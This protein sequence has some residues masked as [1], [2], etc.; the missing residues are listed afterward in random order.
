MSRL[1]AADVTIKKLLEGS[2]VIQCRA[3]TAKMINGESTEI[4]AGVVNIDALYCTRANVEA[5]DDITVGLSRGT[6]EVS[7]N[8]LL[9][10][11]NASVPFKS[12]KDGSLDKF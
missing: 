12:S 7:N 3:L 5:T 11:A 10:G 4:A 1:L 6:I 9:T 8:V 2:S